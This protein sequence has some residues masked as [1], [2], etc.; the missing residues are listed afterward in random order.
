MS[1]SAQPKARS[2]RPAVKSV[3]QAP[4]QVQPWQPMVTTLAELK[5]VPADHSAANVLVEA[6]SRVLKPEEGGIS[7]DPL[8]VWRTDMLRMM[9]GFWNSRSRAAMFNGPSGAGKTALVEQWHAYLR[10]PLF[11]LTGSRRMTSDKILGSPMPNESGGLDWKD[12]PLTRAARS[13]A[14]FL[15]NEI[16]ACEPDEIICMND[17]AQPGAPFEVEMTGELVQPAPTFRIFGTKNPEGGTLYVARKAMDISTRHRFKQFQVGFPSREDEKRI[18]IAKLV[19]L[20]QSPEAAEIASEGMIKVAELVRPRCQEVSQKPDA[21]PE[22]LSPRV[23][24]S[25]AEEW[26]IYQRQPGAVHHALRIALTNGSDPMSAKAIHDTVE[27]VFGVDERGRKS[28]V[29]GAGSL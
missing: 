27:L 3:P 26:V 19:S 28:S 1:S 20:G 8:Y 25:W 24:R 4:V 18:L 10:W 22:V 29:P 2:A 6:G 16:N 7:I 23:L 11:T 9:V 15:F 12:G 14:S 21:I 5:V 17:V 13:G